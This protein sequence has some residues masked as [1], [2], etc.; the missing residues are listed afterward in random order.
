MN[1]PLKP[2]WLGRAA[3]APT[4]AA[5]PLEPVQPHPATSLQACEPADESHLWR[6]R[7]GTILIE[8]RDGTVYVDGDPV[9]P[10][11]PAP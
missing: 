7:Y 4:P 5:Q 11:D 1:A 9:R 8:V 3:S 2:A 10:A 6:G